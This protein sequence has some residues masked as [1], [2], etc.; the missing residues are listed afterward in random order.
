MMP[1]GKGCESTSIEFRVATIFWFFLSLL[2]SGL[3]F[4]YGKGL[5]TKGLAP[6]VVLCLLVTTHLCYTRTLIIYNKFSVF[7]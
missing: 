4:A 5:K 1:P 2:Q 7:L 6:K 3:F